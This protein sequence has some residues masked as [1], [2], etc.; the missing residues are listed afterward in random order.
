MGNFSWPEARPEAAKAGTRTLV[1]ATTRVWMGRDGYTTRGQRRP[2]I[3][4]TTS[5]HCVF[6]PRQRPRRRR[7]RLR[8]SRRRRPRRRVATV[9]QERRAIDFI[10]RLRLPLLL[11]RRRHHHHPPPR[12]PRLYQVGSH[13]GSRCCMRTVDALGALPSGRASTGSRSCTAAARGR[14]SPGPA[15]RDIRASHAP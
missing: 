7:P 15:S 14:S 9:R 5:M 13:R 12:P 6:P 8:R 10:S 2:S 3:Q 4:S 1:P 11:P